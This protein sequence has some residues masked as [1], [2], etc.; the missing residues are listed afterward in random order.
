MWRCLRDPRFSHLS[1]NPT[2][3]RQT[4][5]QTHD[6]GKYRASSVVRV[7]TKDSVGLQSFK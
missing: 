2:C 6:G 3:V 5:G 4:D 1:R 7:K